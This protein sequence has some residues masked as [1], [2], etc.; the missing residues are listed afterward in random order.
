MLKMY[1]DIVQNRLNNQQGI[2]LIT[3]IFVIVIVSMF[4][5]LIARYAM[6][7]SVASAEDYLWAQSLFSAQSAAQSWVLLNDGG[8][9]IGA[10][11]PGTIAG[12]SVSTTPVSS[13]VQS[14]AEIAINGKPIKRTVVIH[15]IQ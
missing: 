12:F 7:S 1:R 14:S 10:A 13:G 4:G 2:G 11:V 15:V 8:G 6:V 5:V 3:A 9:G